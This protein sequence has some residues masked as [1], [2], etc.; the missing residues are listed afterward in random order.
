MKH[1]INYFRKQS[2]G[3]VNVANS[4]LELDI[5]VH[6][7]QLY[8]LSKKSWL[9]LYSKILYKMDQDLLGIR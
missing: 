7:V 9:I 3:L 6:A 1:L 4:A 5:Q 2:Q 8:S